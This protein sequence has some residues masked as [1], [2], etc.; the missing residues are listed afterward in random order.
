[1]SSGNKASGAAPAITMITSTSNQ[2]IARLHALHSPRGRREEQAWLIEGPHALGGRFRCRD[3]AAAYHLRSQLAWSG[4]WR[5]APADATLRSA[6]RWSGGFRGFS[7]GS[8][9]SKRDAHASGGGCRRRRGG[10]H[11]GEG[12]PAPA[13]TPTS[14][15]TGTR[16]HKRSRQPWQYPSLGVG[17]RRR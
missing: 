3:S 14:P 6:C 4:C 17:R 10:S 11:S 8:R 2:H 15:H 16:R 13:G 9:S 12:A 1:M 5:S 7:G